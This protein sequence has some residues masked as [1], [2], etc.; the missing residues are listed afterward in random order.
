MFDHLP[1]FT[2][3]KKATSGWQYWVG[4]FQTRLNTIAD[5]FL[6]NNKTH[7]PNGVKIRKFAPGE[8]AS[9][10]GK[11]CRAMKCK[12]PQDRISAVS[13]L[14]QLCDKSEIGFTKKYWWVINK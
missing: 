12:T 10:L 7:Y 9:D 14:Y 5:G 2:V 11:Y 6:M 8:I 3:E 4:E 13:E 1:K